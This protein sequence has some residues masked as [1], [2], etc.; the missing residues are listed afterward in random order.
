M[1]LI[2]M[3]LLDIVQHI[4]SREILT[5]SSRHSRCRY[6]IPIDYCLLNYEAAQDRPYLSTAGHGHSSR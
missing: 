2:V 6:V 5:C 1:I 4:A 3:V